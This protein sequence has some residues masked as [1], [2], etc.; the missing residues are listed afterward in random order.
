MGLE[1]LFHKVGKS[2]RRIFCAGAIT[3]ASLV[4]CYPNYAPVVTSGPETE[5]VEEGSFY[6][7]TLVVTDA[8]KNEVL[9]ATISQTPS[10]YLSISSPTVTGNSTEWTISGTIPEVNADTE[11]NISIG[12][13]DGEASVPWDY[14][15]TEK[16]I[17]Y[18]PD[19]T[20]TKEFTNNGQVKYIFSGTDDGSIEHIA[21]RFNNT[22]DYQN[23]N[24]ND[25][26]LVQII[27]GN[28]SV[29]ARAYDNEGLADPTPAS[30]SFVSPTEEEANQFIEGILSGRSGTYGHLER[31][32]YIS[33][34]ESDVFHVDLLIR[35]SDGTDAVINYTG[36]QSSLE[37]EL[38]NKGLLDLYGIPNLYLA[39]I[40]ESEMQSQLEDFIDNGYN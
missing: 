18:S 26:V 8:N 4:S 12:I 39:R 40:P 7:K 6:S 20:V 31:D 11:S 10:Q 30:D 28:N 29:E 19:T 14:K 15:L 25:S 5:E 36:H 33:I 16:N 3:L 13:S 17:P 38:Y 34:G 2:A 9:S 24:N 22:G 21:A 37:S 35:K 32:V 1:N 23:F 27:E